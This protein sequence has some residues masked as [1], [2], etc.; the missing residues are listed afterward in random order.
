M[1]KKIVLV[2][3]GL[4]VLAA[5]FFISMRRSHMMGAGG[6]AGGLIAVSPNGTP[7]PIPAKAGSLTENTAMQET[8]GL[9]VSLAI[10]PYPPKGASDFDVTLADSNGPISD[11]NI[12]LDLTMPAMPMPVNMLTMQPSGAGNYHASGFFTMRG[13]WRI[14]VLIDR[15]GKKQ[16]AFFDVSL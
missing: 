5:G 6:P 12:S 4:L 14:E 15:N 11:A 7:M 8:D 2:A 1:T 3:I 9:L 13:L 16:S 10:S